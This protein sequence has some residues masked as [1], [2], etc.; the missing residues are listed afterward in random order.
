MIN[1]TKYI[2]FNDNL[3]VVSHQISENDNQSTKSTDS[4]DNSVL[5]LT[6]IGGWITN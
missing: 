5:T 4:E 1:Y 2:I 6:D 3:L